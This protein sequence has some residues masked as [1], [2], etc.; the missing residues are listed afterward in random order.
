[1]LTSS[2]IFKKEGEA[3]KDGRC[4]TKNSNKDIKKV[5]PLMN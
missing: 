3:I 1:M 2:K 4:P 5:R